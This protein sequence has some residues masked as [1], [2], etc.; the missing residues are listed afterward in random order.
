MYH[1][2]TVDAQLAALLGAM[3]AVVLEGP[4]AC[5]KTRTALQLAKSV[6]RLDVDQNA[7]AIA[8]VDAS[9]LLEGDTPRLIDEWQI[10]PGIWNHVRRAVDDRG[11]PGQ[12]LLTGSAVPTD[13][14]TRHT[15]AL[16]IGRLMMR[17]MSLQ[18]S[19]RSTGAISLRALMAGEPSRSL[20][21]G[22]T[23]PQ[24]AEWIATGGWPG[25]LGRPPEQATLAIRTYVD[26]VRRTDIRRVHGIAHDP[27]RVLQF[28]R[29]LARNTSTLASIA[30]MA[31]DVAGEERPID[32]DSAY[33]YN[34]A[35]ERL[36][37]IED[38]RAWAPHLR[39]KS[40]VR[41]SPKRHFIDPSISVAIMRL[42]PERLLT[43]LNL[44]GLLF[45]S[46]VI[47]DLRVYAQ[48]MDAQIL[49]YKDNTDLEVDAIVEAANGA[50]GA[51][52]I[53]LGTSMVDDA[54]KSLLA[55]RGRV[56]T[57]KCGPPQCLAVITGLGYGY[58]RPDGVQV[59]PIGAL[60]Q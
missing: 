53:K 24:I 45:E 20:D 13:D 6:V 41:T 4:K 2:R 48:A 7:R 47:R 21:P 26:E 37:V 49:H 40:R 32:E 8:A 25:L 19:G 29:S 31:K 11:D 28:M 50:W 52:E 12:F 43:D 38:Q 42:T 58:T 15:G 1:P 60:G 46:M 33:S 39:S 22:T 16:R 27:E 9:L 18:E 14:V 36:M 23:V 30:T 10:E 3:G 55:F 51:F 59:V 35:L 54:A 34:E 17:P 56:D 57:T 44:M 5:G